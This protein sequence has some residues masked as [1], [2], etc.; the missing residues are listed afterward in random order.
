[1]HLFHCLHVG[2]TYPNHLLPSKHSVTSIR[3]D[4]GQDVS[5]INVHCSKY[6][7]SKSVTAGQGANQHDLM[8]YIRARISRPPPLIA[9]IIIIITIIIIIIMAASI[10]QTT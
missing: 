9:E 7:G 5:T 1:M 2:Q 8:E 10:M 4:A 6:E 3:H